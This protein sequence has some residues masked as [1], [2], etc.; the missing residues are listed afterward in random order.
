[1]RK[2]KKLLAILLIITSSAIG[3]NYAL[4]DYSYTAVITQSNVWDVTG[5]VMCL[6]NKVSQS[7]TTISGQTNVGKIDVYVYRYGTVTG[8]LYANI[9]AV[10]GDAPTGSSIGTSLPVSGSG[11]ST[12]GQWVSFIF[13]PPITVSASTK[14]AVVGSMTTGC[15][16]DQWTTF[17]G[18]IL[19]RGSQTSLYSGGILSTYTTQNQYW[20]GETTRDLSFI[21]Y[22]GVNL[23]TCSY[24]GTGD[25]NVLESDNCYITSNTYVNGAFN[26][27]GSS[28]GAFGC[29]NN[30][31]VSAT[32]FNFGTNKTTFDMACFAHH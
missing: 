5:Y 20:N 26:L 21:V 9:Y 27:I 16:Y 19:A 15:T 25:W 14:Y 32:K 10:S 31:K 22:T 8:D 30:I 29:A 7:F 2:I 28:T 3:I 18:G 4:S 12:S 24:S 1:M 11:I 6:T 23:S 13:N 17:T